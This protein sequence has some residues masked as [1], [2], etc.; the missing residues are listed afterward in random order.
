METINARTFFSLI[1]PNPLYE[2]ETLELRAIRRAD[3]E[4]KREFLPSI[5][6]FLKATKN[7]GTGWDI[8]FGISTRYLTGGTKAD[9]YR[10]SCTWVDFDNTVNFLILRK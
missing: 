6:E 2:D 8:Y 1:W 3:K 7:Y 4:V 10:I 9:C 5:S